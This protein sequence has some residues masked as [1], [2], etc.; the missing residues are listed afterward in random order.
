MARMV[1]EVVRNEQRNG[2]NS[3]GHNA[4][5]QGAW[6]PRT[7][8]TRLASSRKPSMAA[9]TYHGNGNDG[10]G[11]PSKLAAPPPT[12][13]PIDNATAGQQSGDAAAVEMGSLITHQVEWHKLAATEISRQLD[14]DLSRGLSANVVAERLEQYGNN[15]LD[16]EKPIPLWKA[17]LLQF[18]NPLILV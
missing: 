11:D 4:A 9:I 12:L 6:T 13:P 2:N 1:T 15:A 10:G 17:F 5:N 7:A 3:D 16:K 18:L 8:L 14:T